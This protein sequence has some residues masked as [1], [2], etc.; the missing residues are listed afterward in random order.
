MFAKKKLCQCLS[1]W[2]CHHYICWCYTRLSV[3]YEK[4]FAIE[5]WAVPHIE[6]VTIVV[7]WSISWTSQWICFSIVSIYP[8][9]C[10]WNNQQT[11]YER[12]NNK[13]P[14]SFHF[15]CI[16][17]CL[18]ND[19][20]RSLFQNRR[21]WIRCFG[22]VPLNDIVKCRLCTFVWNGFAEIN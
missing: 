1:F 2:G 7:F 9:T 13:T 20:L 15:Q 11:K 19:L 18:V 21:L 3:E 22:N 14:H 6:T 8:Q 10:M 12:E 5:C 16:Y 17:Y 4:Y